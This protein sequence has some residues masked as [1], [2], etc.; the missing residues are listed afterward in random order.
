MSLQMLI[1][2]RC[3]D[4]VTGYGAARWLAHAADVGKESAGG[5]STFRTDWWEILRW[6][7]KGL[8]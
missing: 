1:Y 4:G 8:L 3:D 7:L 5:Q 6:R 2:A